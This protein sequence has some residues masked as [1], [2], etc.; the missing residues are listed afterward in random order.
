MSHRDSFGLTGRS[1]GEEHERVSVEV[2]R[3]WRDGRKRSGR[4]RGRE[5]ERDRD[6]DFDSGDTTEGEEAGQNTARDEGGKCEEEAETDKPSRRRKFVSPSF[7]GLANDDSIRLRFPNDVLH[8]RK[9][10]GV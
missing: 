3:F 7:Q 5:L 4:G 6:E 2:E 1:R 9:R 10:K 8:L